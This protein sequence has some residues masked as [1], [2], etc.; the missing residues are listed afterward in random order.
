MLR[1]RVVDITV[2]INRALVYALTTSLVLGLFALLE[3]LIERTA[4]AHRT[5]LVL[6][7]AVPLGLGVSLSTVHRRIDSLVDRLIFRRQYQEEMALRRFA[8][9]SAFVNQP[10]TLLD[11]AVEQIHL[12][13]GAPWV[14]YY[15]YTTQGYRRSRQRGAH[16]LPETV[17][18]DD[19][20]LVKLRAHDS[21]VD[22]HGALSGLGPEGRVFPLRARDHLLGV[23][24]V[25]PRPGEH[26]AAEE[27]ELMDHVA[28]AVGAS[29]FAL[30]A[31]AT[32]EQLSAARAEIET[33]A[34]RLDSARTESAAQLEQARAQGRVSEA[35]LS[36]LR[37][38][39]SVLL[40]ALRA[41]CADPRI[42]AER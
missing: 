19:L 17:P 36:D 18:T 5:S 24:V 35:L 27:R 6:E 28:H 10:E 26:Y 14:A 23:L 34:A 37:S 29:L 3:S 38:R 20:A 30:R 33:S 22:L 21:E 39:E 32:E 12:H 42:P 13:V 1:H 8:N 11:L 31:Q 40:D 2:V 4:L 7:L 15:E 25:G 41:L 16:T 9:E